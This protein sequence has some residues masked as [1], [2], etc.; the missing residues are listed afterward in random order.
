LFS[1]TLFLQTS[2]EIW[3]LLLSFRLSHSVQ[4]SFTMPRESL[5]GRIYS[6][7]RPP[8]APVADTEIP[9]A[10]VTGTTGHGR[11]P[12][13]LTPGAGTKFPSR[14]CCR[15]SAS[16]FPVCDDQSHTLRRDTDFITK[17]CKFRC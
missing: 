2:S 3:A 10:P 16:S 17:L 9:L 12:H 4:A 14:A 1:K 15:K 11:P 13:G 5:V 6:A 8:P 7:Q